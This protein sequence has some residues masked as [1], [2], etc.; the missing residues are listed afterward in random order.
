MDETRDRDTGVRIVP[1]QSWDDFINAMRADGRNPTADTLYRGH[2]SRL[3]PLSSEFERKLSIVDGTPNVAALQ[4]VCSAHLAAFQ[5]MAA[6]LLGNEARNFTEDDWWALGRHNGLNT[7]LL[8]W[9]RSPYV[10]SFFAFSDHRRLADAGAELGE[11]VV[12]W[13]F[14]GW[15]DLIRE[16]GFEI[17]APRAFSN[18]RQRAQR[19]VFTRLT[20][21]SHFDVANYL[22]ERD[23]AD[24]LVRWE[25][26]A[27]ELDVALNDLRLANI[28]PSTLFPDLGG[29]ASEANSAYEQLFESASGST[30]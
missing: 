19:G 5:E 6:G 24:R 2:A 10:S 14:S 16:G 3:W 13:A 8:D 4:A 22:A 7:P 29:A 1:C 28:T 23:C 21:R 11:V 18:P 25:I 15:R 30:S 20:H 17:V 26:P 27:S 9:S 12:I